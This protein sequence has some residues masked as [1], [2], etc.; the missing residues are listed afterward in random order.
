MDQPRRGPPLQISADQGSAEPRPCP[1]RTDRHPARRPVLVAACVRRTAGRPTGAG[2][3]PRAV[4]ATGRRPPRRRR[5]SAPKDHRCAALCADRLAARGGG[6]HH[7][8]S[9]PAGADAAAAAGR[10]RLRQDGGGAAGCRRR[11]RG[12]QAGCADGADGDSGAPAHQD[13]HAAGRARGLAGGD[14]HRPRKGQGAQRDLGAAGSRRDRSAGRHARA[15]PGRRDLQGAGAG[16]RRRAAS[17]W[18]ART[19]GADLQGRGR[20]RAGAERNADPAHAGADLFRRHGRLRTAREAGR[21]A[22]DRYPHD[23]GQPDRRGDRRRRPR[24]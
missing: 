12:R 4:A 10:R 20:R 3:D 11:H 1:G 18:R 9:A 8:G 6:R 21:P 7:R 19:A 22:T 13:H 2:A 14:P 23:T 24:A 16:G 17:I 15:D 5:P